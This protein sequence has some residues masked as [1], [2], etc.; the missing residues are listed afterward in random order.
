M[1]AKLTIVVARAKNGVIGAKGELPWRLPSDLKRFKA[2][3]M[4]KPVIMGRKTWQSL[5][6]APLPG[7]ENIVVTRDRMFR[8][9]GAH[10]F[11][12]LDAAIAAGRAMAA[13]SGADAVCV[14]GGAEIFDAALTQADRIVLTEVDL[15]P[16]G[17]V[18][19]PALDEAAWR[20][21]SREDVARAEK[22]DAAF[23]VRVLERR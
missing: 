19:F 20:E 15:A 14:I 5:P 10:V 18:L 6:K 21:V 4:G 23:S 1:S 11:A 3:T 12:S 2:T 7:R 16:A 17:D 22:D 13:Q 9:I 8:A